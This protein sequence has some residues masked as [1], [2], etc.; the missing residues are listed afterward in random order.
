MVVINNYSLGENV[1]VDISEYKLA[2]SNCGIIA[3]ALDRD[4]EEHPIYTVRDEHG[5]EDFVAEGDIRCL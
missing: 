5:N 2:S 4:S 3:V 1:K